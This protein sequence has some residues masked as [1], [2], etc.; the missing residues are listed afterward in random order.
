MKRATLRIL[1]NDGEV[2]EEEKMMFVFLSRKLSAAA[3]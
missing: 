3:I 2:N 1:K